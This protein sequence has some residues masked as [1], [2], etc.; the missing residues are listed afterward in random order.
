MGIQRR[1]V[2]R[3]GRGAGPAAAGA[4]AGHVSVSYT[5]IHRS[6]YAKNMIKKRFAQETWARLRAK[7][8]ANAGPALPAQPRAFAGD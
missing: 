8:W 5:E 6:K 1:R 4:A 7:S 3:P 2:G